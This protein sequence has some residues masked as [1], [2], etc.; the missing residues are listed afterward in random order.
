MKEIKLKH[1]TS[2]RKGHLICLGNGTRNC[3]LQMR[4]AKAFLAE[5]NRFLTL[6]LHDLHSNY[7]RVWNAYQSNFFY[8]DSQRDKENNA[9]LI[10]MEIVNLLDNCKRALDLSIQRCNYINAN[11]FT[12]THFYNVSDCLEEAIRLISSRYKDRNATSE[13]YQMDLL[14]TGMYII[15]QQL[16][17]R[18]KFKETKHFRVPTHMSEIRE[19]E[20]DLTNLLIEAA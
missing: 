5:T 4:E 17:N 15:R 2:D 11:F 14:I 8:F 16:N 7:I 13:V 20:P 19:Y 1:I 3:F 6:R 10:E 9:Y 18:G 12:F